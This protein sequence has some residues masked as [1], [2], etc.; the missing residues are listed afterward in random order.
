MVK[1]ILVL[2]GLPGCGKTAFAKRLC[3]FEKSYVRINQDD[4]GS[5]AMCESLTEKNI[6][7]GKNVVIDRCN[8]DEDQRKVWVNMGE[9]HG[10]I[11]DALYF[12]VNPKTCK[13]RVKARTGHPTGVEGK[14]GTEVVSRFERLMTRPTVYEGFRYIHN[15][16]THLPDKKTEADV[17]TKDTILAVMA[18]FPPP[19]VEVKEPK[20]PSTPPPKAHTPPP[21]MKPAS[22][23]AAAPTQTATPPKSAAPKIPDDAAKE[24][25]VA[26][27]YGHFPDHGH[28]HGHAHGNHHHH[29]PGFDVPSSAWFGKDFH[30][31]PPSA[32]SSA[33]KNV[34]VVAK[35][36]E[37]HGTYKESKGMWE[38]EA[39]NQHYNHSLYNE[40]AEQEADGSKHL[41]RHTRH[42]QHSDH[43]RN[44]LSG[45]TRAFDHLSLDRQEEGHEL[46]KSGKKTHFADK[47]HFY[48]QSEHEEDAKS[49]NM[50]SYEHKHVNNMRHIHS[51]NPDKSRTEGFEHRSFNYAYKGAAFEPSCVMDTSYSGKATFED[52]IKA[53][54]HNLPA[55]EHYSF[56]Q[57]IS[58]EG[59]LPPKPKM[60]QPTWMHSK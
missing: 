59:G 26:S 47:S 4:L 42:L 57:K 28:G 20:R 25:M 17:F 41:D 12:D 58:W 40:H 18:L 23:P 33:P 50:R 2:V 35:P 5:R 44:P 36:I 37:G 21:S 60:P 9:A 11:V 52:E 3:D 15:V 10:A 30:T 29:H 8:F 39:K 54:F 46:D 7:E 1:H 45:F 31:P 16:T 13:E 34:S 53:S 38:D 19:K 51:G 6:K 43:I 32:P 48:H 24:K 49:G 55:Q 27:H 56:G 22:K 14:F